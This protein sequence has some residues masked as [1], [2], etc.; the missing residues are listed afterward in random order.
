[1]AK[2]KRILQQAY[3][4]LRQLC[5][6]RKHG[7]YIPIRKTAT[8]PEQYNQ[9]IFN[10]PYFRR[11]LN[12]AQQYTGPNSAPINDGQWFADTNGWPTCPALNIA[13]ETNQANMHNG[14]LTWRVDPANVGNPPPSWGPDHATIAIASGQH[15]VIYCWVKT[16]GS[17]GA[18][19]TG[20]RTGL[21]YYG[22]T[23]SGDPI[24]ICG[25][26]SSDEASKGQG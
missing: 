21:D 26:S 22:T 14:A 24:R 10:L 8:T 15:I 25:I 6:E 19:G 12:S 1:M 9:K 2:S 4:I 3:S 16:N 5:T 23:N 11:I 17:A 18:Y 20:A 13:Y 7:L